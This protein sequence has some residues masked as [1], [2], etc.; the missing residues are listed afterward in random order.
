MAKSSNDTEVKATRKR[1]Y[2][3]RKTTNKSQ[4]DL[5]TTAIEPEQTVKP[6]N[7]TDKKTKSAPAKRKSSTK[8]EEDE[9]K[10]VGS[11]K[12]DESESKKRGRKK[13]SET[14][15]LK[16]KV[17]DSKKTKRTTTSK[18]EQAYTNKKVEETNDVDVA[19]ASKETQ[20]TT[21]DTSSTKKV[22]SKKAT[23]VKKADLH[24]K[25]TPD[26]K[27]NVTEAVVNQDAKKE[28]NHKLDAQ[29]NT[30]ILPVDATTITESPAD[31]DA[32]KAVDN[33]ITTVE[34]T[35]IKQESTSTPA[36]STKKSY[37]ERRKENRLKNK[38]KGEQVQN[39]KTDSSD[40]AI[41]KVVNVDNERIIT[42][43]S[44]GS[45][46]EPVKENSA[47]NKL[48][49]TVPNVPTTG[50][51]S[52][53]PASET[54]A[55]PTE[56]PV[57][58]SYW[59]QRKENR[60]KYK[61]EQQKLR[62]DAKEKQIIQDNQQL[63]DNDELPTEEAAKESIVNTGKQQ[64]A[65]LH[66][67]HKNQSKNFKDSKQESKEPK[68]ETNFKD[69]KRDNNGRKE[70][71]WNQ[72]R[73]PK[74]Y[75][76]DLEEEILQTS[77]QQP[78]EDAK[79]KEKKAKEYKAD[80]EKRESDRKAAE[81]LRNRIADYKKRLNKS[82]LPDQQQKSTQIFIKFINEVEKF[83]KRVAY[84]EPGY[85]LV[86]AVSGGVDSV[87]MLDALFILSEKL[88]FELFIAHYN[89]NLRGESSQNDVKFVEQ[90]ASNYGLQFFSSEGNVKQFS[91]KNDL[92]IEAAARTLRYNFYERTARTIE[93]DYVATAHNADDSAET[94]LLNLI[95]G[96]GLTGLAG[97]PPVRPLVKNVQMIRPLMAFSKDEIKK[98]AEI[99][100]LKWSEDE[101]NAVLEFTRNKIRLDLIPKLKQEY[102]PQIVD[103]IIRTSRL[104]EG[105]DDLIKDIV[106]RNL[107]SLVAEGGN[108]RFT[109]KTNILQT[110]TQFMQG[111]LLQ[112]AL[113]KYFR[114]MPASM[115]TIDRLIDLLD[116]EPGAICEITGQIYALRDRNTMIFAKKSNLEN[117]NANINAP[118]E[119]RFGKYRIVISEVNAKPKEFE[120]SKYIEY[121]DADEAGKEFE[122]RNW[123]QGD[124]FKPLGADGRM[125]I[126]DFLINEKV[127]LIDKNKI[128]VVTNKNDIIWVVGM[129][130]DDR[131]KITQK[132]KKIWKVESIKKEE[133]DKNN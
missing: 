38:Q 116:S 93:A 35:V 113:Q 90:K 46:P 14:L 120:K 27:E 105:A 77:E 89:H 1:T 94:F 61:Q 13:K 108:D 25:K 67:N 123:K 74:V 40:K 111:E 100:A 98:Y 66:P 45:T 33:E 125:K 119:Y 65:K 72:N 11:D 115:K 12:N 126:S 15:A 97:I 87:V 41:N 70:A 47:E 117:V 81:A 34:T 31:K 58:K 110:F 130:L 96:T 95:R 42:D 49:V 131:F 36:K 91:E 71:G 133:N 32:F 59:E 109:I 85:K 50:D 8:I 132:T 19:E 124:A 60:K 101:T 29:K 56:K 55:Q 62:Q 28:E 69:E 63:P 7:T 51:S 127:S 18:T 79:L 52:A 64:N 84:I 121:I 39:A 6:D 44:R 2:K 9:V 4:D 20:T 3:S 17:E 103:S 76:D 99:R 48:V 118:G 104:I 114:I 16:E 82:L 30:K 23:I 43:G 92:S 68:R 80:I 21:N 129:R 106:K 10:T 86:A 24:E 78:V 37:W 5:I 102:N 57:K 122:L 26:K 73:S 128:L 54:P 83:L 75:S 53:I 22:A 88:G 112:A 107:Q